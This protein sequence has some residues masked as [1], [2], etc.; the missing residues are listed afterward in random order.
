M[1]SL[2]AMRRAG[3]NYFLRNKDKPEY[4]AKR[5]VWLKKWRQA[6]PDFYAKPSYRYALLKGKCRHRNIDLYLTLG[7]YAALIEGKHCTYCGC[8]IGRTG[9]GLDR[10]NNSKG[11]TPENSVPC[12][13]RCN[14]MKAEL[15]LEQFYE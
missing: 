12:C 9:S 2:E 1:R 10:V 3:R 4:K 8:P 15:T 13:Y 11:Y 6:N 5:A 14:V 7:E